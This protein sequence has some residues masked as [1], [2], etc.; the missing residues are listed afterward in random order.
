M[1]DS[2]SPTEEVFRQ[3]D[4]KSRCH[5]YISLSAFGGCHF[6]QGFYSLADYK[7]ILKPKEIIM[8]EKHTVTLLATI[9]LIL[10]LFFL[11][12]LVLAQGNDP[13]LYDAQSHPV[14][15]H[16]G[17]QPGEEPLILSVVAPGPGGEISSITINL[18]RLI[19]A[20]FY[21][22]VTNE[23]EDVGVDV[24]MHRVYE[25][26]GKEAYLV[27]S[28]DEYE[29]NKYRMA[30]TH[31]KIEEYATATNKWQAELPHAGNVECNARLTVIATNVFNE[32]EYGFLPLVI[33]E[34]P[35]A[36][37]LS[38]NVE[39]ST[40]GSVARPGDN[41]VIKAKATD[42]SSG[43]F[44]VRLGRE[45]ARTVFGDIPKLALTK[46]S[47]PAT[48]TVE[49]TVSPDIE[50]GIYPLQVSAVDRAGNKSTKTIDIEV[51]RKISSL[52]LELHQG[53]N[54][55]SVPKRLKE[56]EITKVF[57]NMPVGSVRTMLGGKWLE[58]NEIVP[59]QGY[60]VK[61]S[62][63]AILT[64]TFKENNPST[65]P[66]AIHFEQG[67]NL[68][69]YA[70]QTLKPKM[71]LRFYLGDELKGKW[72]VLYTENRESARYQS[73]KPYVWASEDFPTS[74][75]ESYSEDP[76]TNLPVVESGKGY[77]IYFSEAGTLVP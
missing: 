53:W 4:Y 72:S 58:V 68:L 75:G 6:A 40:K 33:V 77:W 59:G 65:M 49:H 41:I 8:R 1:V 50:K 19:G 25:I 71:P 27:E 18:D 26:E 14:K 12:S 69:G 48:W 63:E 70:S 22:P 30:S 42:N 28:G 15:V 23:I 21:D 17:A 29:D 2:Y 32:Q 7:E 5:Q 66:P 35:N 37:E 76:S 62:E 3:P 36:P 73:T 64:A 54:L 51:K 11:P 45:N 24:P 56:S 43:V 9:C 34:D 47:E 31:E 13:K 60:L 74:T 20:K 44:S 10:I 52:Q 16:T 57:A 55:I 61:S 39:Y 46:G 38:L 67:W